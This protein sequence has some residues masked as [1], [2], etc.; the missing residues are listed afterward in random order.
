MRTYTVHLRR[1]ADAPA[2]GPIGDRDLVLIK[3]GFAWPAFFFSVLWALRHRMWWGA[4]ALVAVNGIGAALVVAFGMNPVGEVLVNLGV[5]ILI[6][7]SGNDL[8]RWTLGRSGFTELGVV[9]AENRTA[10]ERR[11]LETR[12]WLAAMLSG[13]PEKNTAGPPPPPS[14]LV[15][16]NPS[17]VTP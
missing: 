8:R 10:A 2:L 5:A 7:Q 11:F 3:E 17:P 13:R 6:G 14:T 12:P 4:L 1:S 9:M 15:S 16:H